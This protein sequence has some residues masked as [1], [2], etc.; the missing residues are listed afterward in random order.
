MYTSVVSTP[1]IVIGKK[2]SLLVMIMIIIAWDHVYNY[3]SVSNKPLK[4]GHPLIRTFGSGP[5]G[6]QIKRFLLYLLVLYTYQGREL[7]HG[8]VTGLSLCDTI[9]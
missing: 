8:K 6:V 1:E 3:N 9:A 4:C 2:N 5:I 7:L